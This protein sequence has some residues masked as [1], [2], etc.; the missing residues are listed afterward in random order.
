MKVK[1]FNVRNGLNIRHRKENHF[2]DAYIGVVVDQG[3]LKKVVDLRIY[4]TQAMNYVCIW[5]HD[6]KNDVHVNGSGSAGGYGYHRPSAALHE[7]LN[8]MGVEL[9]HAI[10][11]R[12][13]SIMQ[14]A[15]MA[16]LRKL[17][18]RNKIVEIIKAHG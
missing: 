10:A 8:S 12:G 17:Y 6:D 18:P 1:K 3:Q 11:G 5:I 13:E 9:T 4:G 16:I 15:V 2:Q 7:A 14:E